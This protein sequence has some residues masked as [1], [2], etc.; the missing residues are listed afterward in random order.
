MGKSN[1]AMGKSNLAMGKS[2]LAMGKWS[3]I[4]DVYFLL[5]N[6]GGIFRCNGYVC[7]FKPGG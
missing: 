3:R 1:L 6:G 4:E 7:F 5:K 2:N